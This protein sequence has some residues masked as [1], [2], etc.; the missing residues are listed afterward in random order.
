MP[1][2]AVEFE[3]HA[4]FIWAEIE[5]TG[6]FHGC[7]MRRAGTLTPYL[8]ETILED[9]L[10]F[11]HR[12]RITVAVA[13]D[14][15]D[16]TLAAVRAALGRARRVG[17]ALVVGRRRQL[18]SA[19]LERIST[20]PLVLDFASRVGALLG[21]IEEERGVGELFVA[22]RGTKM[23]D[24]LPVLAAATDVAIAGLSEVVTGDG[25]GLPP[26]AL[27]PARDA[28]ERLADRAAMRERITTLAIETD[29]A[30]DYYSTAA[31]A[32]LDAAAAVADATPDSESNR[33][34]KAFVALLRVR[35]SVAVERGQLALA[36]EE[37]LPWQSARITL[38]SLL[39]AQAAGLDAFATCA[40][41]EA[42]AALRHRRAE[43][44][45]AEVA[46][47]EQRILEGA[48]AEVDAHGWFRAATA[49]LEKLR[50]VEAVQ[51]AAIDPMRR[52]AIGAGAPA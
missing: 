16:H 49:K 10:R 36:L 28:L 32:L 46:R 37:T 17:A 6:D 11:R 27:A 34:T 25:E 29:G 42:V 4:P 3:V 20:V 24:E 12:G 31:R 15:P 8:A 2:T 14:A 48:P 45:F 39:D 23:R 38:H 1:S 41:P 18:A 50:E 33:L 22:S 44:A 52:R 30:F 9:A 19:A 35:E 51:L 43:G 21:A 47:L 26:G 5:P 40:A 13:D 7:A